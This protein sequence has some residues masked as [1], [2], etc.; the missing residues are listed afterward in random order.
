MTPVIALL[1]LDDRRPQVCL[2]CSEILAE[3]GMV[4]V[5]EEFPLNG[6]QPEYSV[7]VYRITPGF[8]LE[9]CRASIKARHIGAAWGS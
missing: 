5:V 8:T 4:E 1:K 6:H 7:I 3:L 2:G 9:D